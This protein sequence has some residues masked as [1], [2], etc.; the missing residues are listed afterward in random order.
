MELEL[1]PEEIAFRDEVRQLLQDELTDELKAATAKT[2]TVFAD[3]DVALTWQKILHKRGWAGVSWPTEFGGTGWSSTQRYLFNQECIKAGAPGLIPLGLRMLAPV[4]FKYGTKEQQDYY[5]PR[6]LSGE[7]YWCQGYSEPGSGSDLASLKTRA[8]RDGDEYV[9]NGTKIWTTHAHFAD[10]IFCLVRTDPDVRPQAGITFLL[11]DMDTPG[12]TV[13]PII[14]LAGDHEVNQ[15]FLEDVRVPV[16]NRVGPENEGWAVAK[17]LLEFERGGG[18]AATG[19]SLAMKE[20]YLLLDGVLGDHSLRS[21]ADEISIQISALSQMETDLQARLARGE[22]PGSNSSL[23]KNMTSSLGQQIAALRL[24]AVDYYGIPHN[25]LLWLQDQAGV[26]VEKNQTAIGTYLNNR[27]S[28]IFGGSQE[29][30]KNIIAK[31]VL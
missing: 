5:L 16:T 2:T 14:T 11:I 27:A 30:Q 1:T 9:V 19:L 23:M 25:N 28:S 21:R 12:I 3:K 8:I 20:L 22:N 13:D 24:E 10:H 31:A 7:H 18:A 6:I 29:V 4:L 15:V 26:G 17:Y